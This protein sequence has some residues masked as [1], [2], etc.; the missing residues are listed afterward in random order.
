MNNILAQVREELQANIDLQTQKSFQRF[1]KEQVK[2][3]GVKTGIV[4][5]IAKK[6]WKQVKISR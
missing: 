1:F 5:K 3:Y 4:G 6:Y 2:Y